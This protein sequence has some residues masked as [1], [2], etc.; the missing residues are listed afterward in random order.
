MSDVSVVQPAVLPRPTQ[1]TG[2]VRPAPRRRRWPVPAVAVACAAPLYALW[3]WLLATGGG[4]L[5]AQVAWAGFAGRH[6]GTPYNLAWYGGMHTMDYSVL[7]PP[8]MAYAGV[9]AVSVAAGLAATWAMAVLFVRSGVRR[10]MVPA[11]LGAVCQW[12]DVASGRTTFAVGAAF[13][14]LA[15]CRVRRAPDRWAGAAVLAAL[16]AMSS[17]VAALFLWVAGAG[18]L[19]AGRRA[20]ALALAAPPVLVLGAVYVLFPFQGEQLMSAD[21]AV[22]PLATS[23]ALA[24]AAPRSWRTVRA[25]AV[26]YAL[27]TALTACVASPVGTNV[28]RL[29]GIAGLPL[30]AAAL[31]ERVARRPRGGSYV[32][33]DRGPTRTAA[34]APVL[35]A[36]LVVVLTGALGHN[37]YALAAKTGRELRMSTAVPD[38]ASHTEGVTRAL[39]EL[40]AERHRIEVVPARDHRES[41]LFAD[42][43]QIAR[44]WNRQ[45]DVK[46]DPLF[47]GGTLPDGTLPAAAYRRW[48]DDWAVAYV[49][50][51]HGDMGGPGAAE[52]ALLAPAA[53]PDWLRPVWRDP[54]WTVFAVERPVPLASAPARV[55]RAGEADVTVRLPKAGSTVVRVAWSPWFRVTGGCVSRAGR[56]T[57]ITAPSAG[58]YRL[59]SIY[60]RAKRSCG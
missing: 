16:T 50:L 6:P 1:R 27:G 31:M 60:S 40:R 53:R 3:A 9:R 7:T 14:L 38:W 56:W 44:G 59:Y 24:L 43:A 13:G 55:L 45:L 54:Y 12:C 58:D 23:L 47:Y 51:P 25:G 34:R 52:A 10:P 36:V 48:L 2:Q 35:G 19:A 22:C 39:R 49:V 30:L 42:V 4:D 21:A 20:A 29:A 15:L 33:L 41:T 46:R 5:A 32:R 17:P 18:L 8:L 11:L 28:E 26:A 37:G 57:R